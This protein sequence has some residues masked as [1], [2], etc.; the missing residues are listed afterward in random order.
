ME[1]DLVRC[2]QTGSLKTELGEVVEQVSES[3]FKFKFTKEVMS[4]V[5]K[6]VLESGVQP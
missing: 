6:W 3:N 2:E 1:K 5:S 4:E